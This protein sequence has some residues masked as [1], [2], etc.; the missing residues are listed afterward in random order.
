MDTGE[1]LEDLDVVNQEFNRIL[2]GKCRN[3]FLLP[4]SCLRSDF[5][6]LSVF[7]LFIGRLPNGA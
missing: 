6:A 3:H 7:L 1:V 5:M 2:K 4:E